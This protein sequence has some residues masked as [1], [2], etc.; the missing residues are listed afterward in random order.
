MKKIVTILMLIVLLTA[1]FPGAAHADSAAPKPILYTY[2]RQMGWGDRIEIGYVDS[3][4]DLWFLNGHDAELQWPYAAEEQIR[5]LTSHAFEK[6]GSLKY[7]DLFDLKSLVSAVQKSD[8][9]SQPAANDAGTERT[10]A[11]RWDRDGKAEPVLLGMSG[12]DMFENPDANAQGL[13]LRAAL[14]FPGVTRYGA[15]MGPM[16][17]LPVRLAEFCEL[18]DLTGASVAAYFM[19]CESGP[20][21]IPLSDAEQAQILDDV[22]NCVVTGKVSAA[23]TTGG[24][25]EYSFSRG[26]EYLGWISI[27]DGYLYWK[28]GMY[29]IEKLEPG[30]TKPDREVT[31]ANP[32]DG[33]QP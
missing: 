29:S 22:M 3:E 31:P 27:Y 17:F 6:I 7:D 9:P 24:Y 5:Y 4:G 11:I 26:N 23:V 13:Y 20:E 12:D 30:Q 1:L 18:G 15:P 8:A 25:R 16:G 21:E 14:L 33:R 28:D 32:Y 10:T 2:Y 19:D